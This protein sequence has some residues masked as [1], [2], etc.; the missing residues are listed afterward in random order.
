MY[1]LKEGDQVETTEEAL[2]VQ[3]KKGDVLKSVTENYRDIILERA[4][5]IEHLRVD[6]ISSDETGGFYL[7][8]PLAIDNSGRKARML[9]PVLSYNPQTGSAEITRLS[10]KN[11][12]H[13][14][15]TWKN[16]GDKVAE[17]IKWS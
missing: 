5:V 15:T 1:L 2:T 16:L 4:P 17:K 7:E 11:L 3:V 8:G 6:K 13:E 10:E 9:K 14:R 12:F